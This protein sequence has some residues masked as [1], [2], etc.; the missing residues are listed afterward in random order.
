MVRMR[1]ARLAGLLCFLWLAAPLARSAVQQSAATPEVAQPT[2][3][4]PDLDAA[5]LRA[6]VAAWQTERAIPGLSVAIGRGREVVFACGVGQADVENDVPATERTVYRLASVSKPI[7]AVVILQLVEQQRL[8]LDQDVRT[9]L[10]EF[11]P[12]RAVTVQRLLGHL[13]GVRHYRRGEAESTERY[14]TQRHGLVRFAGDPLVHDPGTAFL[15]STY[16]Y[17][18]LAA[19]AEVVAGQPFAALVRERIA[20]PADAPSLRDDDQQAIIPHRAQGYVRIDG[21]LR[22]ARLMDGSYKLGGG[23]LCAN[24]PDLVRFGLALQGGRLVS[25]AAFAAMTTSMQDAA[26]KATGYGMGLRIGEHRG[27]REL[28]HAGAQARVSTGL[29]L[30]PEQQLAAVVLCNLEGER[31]LALAREL[32][33]LL[34]P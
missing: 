19:V 30:W 27:R 14:A 28:A 15:Y 33:D 8:R 20:V 26:G 25:A 18:L 10:P 4:A 22:N 17:N 11:A 3:R 7:T 2:G 29:V 1:P 23:G 6:R 31:P 21:E 5:A 24:A 34:A 12:D 13:G 9:L 32:L 16:G